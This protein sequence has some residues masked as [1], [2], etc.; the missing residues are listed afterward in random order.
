V[1]R[2]Y[3]SQ[4]EYFTGTIVS[5]T[6]LGRFFLEAFPHSA[7]LYRPSLVPYD[8]FR[9]DNY[10]TAV[11]YLNVIVKVDPYQLKFGD[12]KSLKGQEVYS[13][14][15]RRH[16]FTGE[17]PHLLTNSDFRNTYSLTGF[18]GID[19]RSS[20]VFCSIHDDTNDATEFA[21]QVEQAIARG[22]FHRRDILVLDNAAIHIGKENTVL[23]EWLWTNFE[24]YVLFLPPRSPELNPIE[25]VWGILVQRLRI[26]PLDELRK[27]GA[28]SSAIKSKHILAE[29][30]HRE[31]EGCFF[32]CKI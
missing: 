15:V 14:K 16:P 28:H 27:I 20:A 12:E 21:V 19:R 23:E 32:K 11:E 25:L 29:I 6:T 18:C 22:Y 5:E 17:I 10:M 31:V 9:P 3:V 1:S 7:A 26:V 8:K 30:T 13:R 24:I 2:S 4:L